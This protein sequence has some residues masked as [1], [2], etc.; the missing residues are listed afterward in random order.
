MKPSPGINETR[1]KSPSDIRYTSFEI[2]L[3]PVRY[4]RTRK[5][6]MM[7]LSYLMMPN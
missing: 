6:I 4:I 1:L 7:Y 2:Q 5:P 3:K